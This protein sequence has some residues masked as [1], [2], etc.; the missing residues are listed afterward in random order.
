MKNLREHFDSEHEKMYVK[1]RH[2][3]VNNL[4]AENRGLRKFTKNSR[5]LSDEQYR[6]IFTLL[7]MITWNSNEDEARKPQTPN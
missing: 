6:E 7:D 3:S 2:A 4:S 5:Q 1:P